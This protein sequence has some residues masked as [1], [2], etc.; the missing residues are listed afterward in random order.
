M[1]GADIRPRRDGWLLVAAALVAAGLFR[2]IFILTAAHS[3]GGNAWMQGDW[4][5]NLAGGPV[6]RGLFGTAI[7]GLADATG[8]SALDL[9]VAIQVGLSV[10]LF[11][12][13]ILL[14][15]KQ[16][17]PDMVL[18]V[19][20]PG[21]FFIAWVIDPASTGRKELFGLLSLLMI[22]FPG[23]G[24][25][26]IGIS[27]ALIVIGAIGHEINVLIMPA[28][29]AAL[30][31]FPRPEI[32]RWRGMIIAATG[33]PVALSA[34]YAALN[35]QPESN[36]SICLALTERGLSRSNL[37][38]GAIEWLALPDNGPA[39]VATALSESATA[40]L[41]PLAWLLFV[42]PVARLF[43]SIPLRRP[44]LLSLLAGVLP[45]LL[46]Y[47]IA[48]DWGRWIAI[49]T[50]IAAIFALG[51]GARGYFGAARRFPTLELLI[52]LAC[53]LAWGPRHLPGVTVEGFLSL[54]L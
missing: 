47:P 10:L 2:Q 24:A 4:L 30:F 33:L 39:S 1:T 7:L 12:G 37:C 38:G 15:L 28:W 46:L 6:R 8:L 14:L 52:W 17:G 35:P 54:F 49:Q 48:L 44:V 18:A 45:V 40:A 26:R 16:P 25:W 27:A 53:A 31:L 32:D 20:S 42:V 41:V 23:G 5:I 50:T 29:I 51:L 3:V 36:L 22:A 13:V 11:G 9:V 19:L 43:L 21:I 34:L